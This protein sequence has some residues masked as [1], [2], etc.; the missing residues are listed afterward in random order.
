MTLRETI[1]K[2]I[3]R[4]KFMV[5]AGAGTAVLGAASGLS[6]A[7]FALAE[8]PRPRRLRVFSIAQTKT[9]AAWWDVLAV[10]AARAGVPLD[11]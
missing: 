10:G 5:R 1:L 9:Y 2:S 11:V 4:T 3:S 6:P 8:G 7:G